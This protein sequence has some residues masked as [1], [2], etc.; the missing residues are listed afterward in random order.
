MLKNS[1][2]FVLY[3]LDQGHFVKPRNIYVNKPMYGVIRKL[4]QYNLPIS[5]L[6]D[7]FDKAVLPVL[8]YGC[9]IWEYEN[10][11]AVELIHLK[12]LKHILQL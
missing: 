11:Q 9:E 7:L 8:I 3:F 10:L 1:N 4:R 5:C 2:I 6:S 12:F